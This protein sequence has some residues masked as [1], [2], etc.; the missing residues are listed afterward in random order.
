[1]LQR[2]KATYSYHICPGLLN[3]ASFGAPQRRERYIVI[4]TKRGTASLPKGTFTEQ[5]YRTVRDAIEEI[6][7]VPTSVDVK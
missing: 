2:Q 5:T 4:G 3:A 7:K 1:M 6:E